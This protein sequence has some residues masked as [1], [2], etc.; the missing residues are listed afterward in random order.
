MK[1]CKIFLYILNDYISEEICSL[2]KVYY[3]LQK[4]IYH[5]CRTNLTMLTHP[6]CGTYIHFSTCRVFCQTETKIVLDQKF[7]TKI[8]LIDN[9]VVSL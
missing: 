5:L 6:P 3:L 4:P 1:Y 2:P 8:F 7:S 9:K